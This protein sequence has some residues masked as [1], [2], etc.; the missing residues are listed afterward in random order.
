M[1]ATDFIPPLAAL[2]ITLALTPVV[3]I[4]ARRFSLI[5]AP[6]DDRWHETPTPH[7][8]GIA[9]SSGILVA[10]V[11]AGV[12]SLLIAG[13]GL[14]FLVGLVDDFF[15]LKPTVRIVFEIGAAGLALAG[16]IDGIVPLS[17][18]GCVALLWIVLVSNAVNLIDGADGVS[19]SVVGA[20]SLIGGL[21]LLSTGEI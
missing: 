4:L 18:A 14:I 8:G 3:K 9:M 6:A 1:T 10:F 12:N 2:A 13:T 17:V 11:L 7:Y 16:G 21:F 19:S 20:V 15:H 5:A